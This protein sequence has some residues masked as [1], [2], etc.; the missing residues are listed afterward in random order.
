[1]SFSRD[2]EEQRQ[3]RLQ[4]QNAFDN[5]RTALHTLP[6]NYLQFLLSLSGAPTV[7][8]AAGFTRVQIYS[9]AALIVK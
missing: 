4:E 9:I 1:M 5:L 3:L 8:D 2:A 6:M 7:Q